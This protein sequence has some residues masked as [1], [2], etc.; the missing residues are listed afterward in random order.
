M[1]KQDRLVEEIRKK[2]GKLGIDREE[3]ESKG[4]PE[5][6]FGLLEIETEI[7]IKQI[8]DSWIEDGKLDEDTEKV[9]KSG[10]DSENMVHETSYE[11][12]TVYIPSEHLL[13]RIYVE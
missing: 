11:E 9:R 13:D 7:P 8:R 12:K 3:A 6:L 5:E 10:F 4:F 1:E 2:A